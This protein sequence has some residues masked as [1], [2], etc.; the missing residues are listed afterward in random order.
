VADG[1]ENARLCEYP[2]RMKAIEC[3]RHGFA[4][5]AVHMLFLAWEGAGRM[6]VSGSWSGAKGGYDAA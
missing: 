3:W 2:C 1:L 5:S 6:P 4:H